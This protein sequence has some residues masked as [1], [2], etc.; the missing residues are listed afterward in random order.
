LVAEIVA[1]NIGLIA[2]SAAIVCAIE[3]GLSV[4]AQGK[5]AVAGQAAITENEKLFSKALILAAIT[6]TQ[7]I[8][9]LV[10]ALL[11]I[12]YGFGVI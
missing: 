8:Y 2:L 10:V 12:F 6:E 5:A 7:A 3:G 11:L 1:Q 4:L 9:A